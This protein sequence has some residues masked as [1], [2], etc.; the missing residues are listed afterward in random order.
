MTAFPETT[1]VAGRIT[2]EKRSTHSFGELRASGGFAVSSNVRK[3]SSPLNFLAASKS[4][5]SNIRSRKDVG[6]GI[7]EK[8]KRLRRVL[9]GELEDRSGPQPEVW[10]SDMG[11]S[12]L[13]CLKCL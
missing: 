13:W 9:F 11:Q 1:L 5:F 2:D 8:S 3:S 6:V 10:S 12:F 7:E 4:A